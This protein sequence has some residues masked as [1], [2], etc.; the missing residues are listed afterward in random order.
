MQKITFREFEWKDG[1]ELKLLTHMSY[2]GFIHGSLNI[3]LVL[4]IN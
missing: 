4:S 3:S 1:K 2:D